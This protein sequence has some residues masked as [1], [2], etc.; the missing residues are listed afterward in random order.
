MDESTQ[1][2]HVLELV[3]MCGV[4]HPSLTRCNTYG[5]AYL[6]V[7]MQRGARPE[8]AAA[9]LVVGVTLVALQEAVVVVKLTYAHANCSQG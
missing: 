7:C 1:T 5:S 4:L 9:S 2:H 3:A 6:P 8:L